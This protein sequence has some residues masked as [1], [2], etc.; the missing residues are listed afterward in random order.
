MSRPK[1]TSP[2][3]VHRVQFDVDHPTY[4]TLSEMVLHYGCS[5][6]QALVQMLAMAWREGRMPILDKTSRDVLVGAS[7]EE[8]M[9]EARR[10]ARAE[11]NLRMYELGF[12]SDPHEK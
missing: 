8:V 10:A 1:P 12:I 5:S 4:L 6:R 7:R 11:V 9:R 2:A 3:R